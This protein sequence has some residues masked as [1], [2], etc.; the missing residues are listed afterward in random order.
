MAPPIVG[1]NP[2]RQAESSSAYWTGGMVCGRK[3]S[4]YHKHPIWQDKG[5]VRF[6]ICKIVLLKSQCYDL[7]M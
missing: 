3:V 1:N 7:G 6:N 5:K 4:L 2:A